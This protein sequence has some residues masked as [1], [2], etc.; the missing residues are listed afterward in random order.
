[1]T[2]S[3]RDNDKIDTT[4]VT[5]DVLDGSAT[6]DDGESSSI[7]SSD[8][9]LLE[10]LGLTS[11]NE[12]STNHDVDENEQAE[13][14]RENHTVEPSR[15]VRSRLPLLS[16]DYLST[17]KFLLYEQYQEKSMCVFPHQYSIPADHM[18]K[19][20]E[21][22]IWGGPTVH[23]DRS[24]ET[25]QVYKNGTIEQRR[26]L[27]RLENFVDTHPGWKDLCCGYLRQLLS[28][29][30]GTEMVLFK[31]KLNLKPPGGSGF[32]PHLDSPSL[33]VAMGGHGPQTFCTVMVAIDDA[34]SKNGCLRIC[35]GKWNEAN[36]CTVIQ[37]EQDGNPDAGGRAGAIPSEVADQLDFDDV[38]CKGGTI[39][40]FNGWAPHRSGANASPFPRR[41]VF[42]TYNPKC[43]GDF[44]QKYY[45]RME[46][47]RNE[48]REKAGLSNQQK[49]LDDEKLE[50]TALS[51]IP[52]I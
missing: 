25:I 45:Q 1:M 20:T 27:T 2:P 34:N 48:W 36:A 10:M 40:A 16:Q 31:E 35:K 42:L 49:R 50:Q 12:I 15:E 5:N 7:A 21:E 17:V 46:K 26:T 24:Y 8:K 28:A 9:A 18:R 41:A 19:L 37:P 33:R 38:T 32:A 44:H 30:L 14:L 52:K 39:V 4:G 23:A 51:T 11:L 43:E 13:S 47:L 6:N 29:A 22:L 3:P